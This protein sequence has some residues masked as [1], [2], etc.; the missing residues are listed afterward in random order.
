MA[1]WKR[2]TALKHGQ[3]FKNSN[4]K[5]NEVSSDCVEDALE[6]EQNFVLLS[7]RN[8][9]QESGEEKNLKQTQ[10]WKF[11][12]KWH[13]ETSERTESNNNSDDETSSVAIAKNIEANLHTKDLSDKTFEEIM[14]LQS[15]MGTKY[16]NKVSSAGKKKQQTA[17]HVKRLSKHRPDEISAKNPVT[18]FRRVAPIKKTTIRDPRFDDLSGEFKPEVFN[19]TYKFINEIKQREAEMVKKR[20]RKSKSHSKREEMKSLLKRME[21]QELVRKNQEQQREKEL[22]FKRKQRELVGHGHRPFYLK[23]CATLTAYRGM[24]YV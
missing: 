19:Q 23:K 21:N 18:F 5:H 8:K 14:R 20:L 15:K 24:A 1:P 9:V 11:A 17:E 6:M 16:Y 4:Q 3:P 10:C 2:R 22:R 7:K 13:H 12:D